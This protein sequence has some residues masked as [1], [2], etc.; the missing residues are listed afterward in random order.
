MSGH[1]M[2][3][4]HWTIVVSAEASQLALVVDLGEYQA[5]QPGDNMLGVNG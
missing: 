3:H 1:S 5:R 2:S 4:R